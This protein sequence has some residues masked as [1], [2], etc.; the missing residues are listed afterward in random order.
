MLIFL[1]W[2]GVFLIVVGGHGYWAGHTNKP[3]PGYLADYEVIVLL[4]AWPA[5]LLFISIWGIWRALY[6][7][8]RG[9]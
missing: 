3:N 6:A 4:L 8:G 2:L 5:I 1:I 7:L 9:R